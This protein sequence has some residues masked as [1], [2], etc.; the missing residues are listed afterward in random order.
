MFI[1]Y[2][3]NGLSVIPVQKGQKFPVIKE[4]QKY[5]DELPAEEDVD[6]WNSGNYNIG[7]ACGKASRVVVV[8]IDTDDKE[9]L[10]RC[11]QSPV[12]RRGAKGEARFFKYNKDIESQSV[13]L[14]DILSSGRQVVVPPSIHPTTREPYI[15]LTKDTLDNFD[16]DDLPELHDLSFLNSTTVNNSPKVPGRN[17]HLVDL[18]TSMRGRGEPEELIV[19]EVFEWDQSNHNPP[20]FSDKSEGFRGDPRMNA[21]KFVNRVT[22]TLINKGLVSIGIPP[23]VV[24]EDKLIQEELFKP[25]EFPRPTGLMDDIMTLIENSS[26]RLMPNLALGGAMAVMSSICANRYRFGNVWPNVFILNLAPTGSGKSFPQRIIKELLAE[27]SLIGYGSYKSSSAVTKNL[28]SQRER[29]DIIDEFSGPLGQIKNGG[30]Y[31]AEIGEELCKL[32]SE[33]NTKFMGGEYAGKENTSTCYNP[34]VTILGSS[35][36]EG[37]KQN[38]DASMI[39]KGLLPRFTIFSHE[40]YGAIKRTISDDKLFKKTKDKIKKFTKIQKK[41]S[42]VEVSPL[43]GPKY[44]PTD[45]YPKCPKTV[46]LL[47]KYEFFYLKEV[48]NPS[49]SEP[50]KQMVSRASEKMAKNIIF[51][52]RSNSRLEA[53]IEDIEWAKKVVDVE[54]YNSRALIEESSSKNDW[55]RFLNRV[56]EFIKK[57]HKGGFITHGVLLNKL[58]SATPREIGQ[59]ITQLIQ[60]EQIKEISIENPRTKKIYKGYQI[61]STI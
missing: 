43:E 10:G 31:Q 56:L 60:S 50:Q 13:P 52:C 15:W 37:I 51:S 22:S 39:S 20:L 19:N 14:I 59:C 34:C 38:I 28:I 8:D 53:T 30:P 27:T 44:N 3:E 46:E 54:L 33:S 5:C 61:I 57:G 45:L 11:P 2:Y 36:I 49:F 32:W 6:R 25:K 17:N 26:V 23:K 55:E 9:I 16:L 29:L 12:V 40:G 24:V 58:R 7:I 41:R 42:N 21:W 18:V 48:E 4:W 47:E 1:K 35:T